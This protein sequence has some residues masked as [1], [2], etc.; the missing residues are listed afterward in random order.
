MHGL[1]LW[2]SFVK[3]GVKV[4]ESEFTLVGQNFT[5]MAAMIYILTQ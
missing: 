1:T 2:A 5:Q 3:A 4:L